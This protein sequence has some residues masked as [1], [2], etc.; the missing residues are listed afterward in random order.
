MG[1]FKALGLAVVAMLAIG[2]SA[3]SAASAD[4]FTAEKYPALIKGKIDPATGDDFTTTFSPY[5]C[6]STTYL[7]TITSATTTVSV[8]PSYSGC[9]FTNWLVIIDMKDCTYLFHVEGGTS[10]NGD[11]DIVCPPGE[12]ISVTIGTFTSVCTIHFKSQSDINGPVKFTNVGG[13]KEITVEAKLTGLDYTHTK[14][15]GLA[16]CSSGSGTN[17]TMT[18][19]A[20]FGTEG[21]GVFMSNV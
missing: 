9:Q 2:A 11:M 15:T 3:V 13:G 18:V 1:N 8:T 14:G 6:V 21:N 20:I 7:A 5:R 10:T 16:A 19:K 17:G 12:E 4:E